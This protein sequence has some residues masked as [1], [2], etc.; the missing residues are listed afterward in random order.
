MDVSI[1]DAPQETS[2]SPALTIIAMIATALVPMVVVTILARVIWIRSALRKWRWLGGQK[3]RARLWQEASRLT[4]HLLGRAC[5]VNRAALD[6]LVEFA[7][8]EPNTPAGWTIIDL[9]ALAIGH[10]KIDPAVR[11]Q[12]AR[13]PG[14]WGGDRDV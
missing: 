6:D 3:G 10:D 7:P 14:L 2:A 12:Q 9:N 8:V 13:G 11:A 5:L 1:E 4:R